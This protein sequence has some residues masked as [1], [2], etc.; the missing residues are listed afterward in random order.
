MPPTTAKK[1]K[2]ASRAETVKNAPVSKR[3]RPRTSSTTRAMEEW[4]GQL[5]MM[6]SPIPGNVSSVCRVIRS[7]PLLVE[8]MVQCQDCFVQSIGAQL[9]TPANAA[10]HTV[11][12]VGASQVHSAMRALGIPEDLLAEVRNI[13]PA[14]ERPAKRKKQTQWSVN[15]IAEQ[16]RLLASSKEKML[17]NT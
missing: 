8:A 16:E 12:R 2:E 14:T 11:R 17:G 15:D 6:D 3:R 5:A 13:Q 7:S 1:R 4:L 9:V 10:E